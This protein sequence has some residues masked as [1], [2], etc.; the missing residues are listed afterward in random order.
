MQPD[1]SEAL[2]YLGI[3]SDPDGAI[4]ARMTA[5]SAELVSRITPQK[6]WRVVSVAHQDGQPV[7]DGT[8]VL[9]GKSAAR[10]LEDCRQCAL[11]V[12]TLGIAFDAWV[13]Q[14]QAR[15]MTRAVMLDAL[16]SAYV[17][18]ACDET[19]REIAARFPNMYL[20]DRFSPGYGDLPLDVQPQLL[21]AA[22]AHRIGVTLTSSRLMLPQKSVSALIGLAAVPQQARIRGCAH[23]AM[24]QTC[25]LRK[26]GKTCEP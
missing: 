14:T 18:A 20:T 10:L 19:E 21:A 5:L 13:R 15:D 11:L 6:M 8:L 7:L 16:G 3:R 4:T 1:I 17:E 23:C 24:R 22:S 12:C 25:S 26:A 9:P 2:R